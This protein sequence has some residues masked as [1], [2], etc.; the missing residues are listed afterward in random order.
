MSKYPLLPLVSALDHMSPDYN[1]SSAD[2]VTD[3]NNL[4]KLLQWIEGPRIPDFR[5]DLQL[6]GD[7]SVLFT[8][9]DANSIHHPTDRKSLVYGLN[10][11]RHCTKLYKDCGKSTGHHRIIT[12]VRDI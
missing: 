12:Y 1:L 9:W 5:M 11:E 10:F 2:I 6:A 4:R 8:R 7:K 3:R